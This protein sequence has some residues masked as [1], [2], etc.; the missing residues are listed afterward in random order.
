MG[1]GCVSSQDRYLATRE[2]P[3]EQN[4]LPWEHS[5]ENNG[6]RGG[7]TDTESLILYGG[8]KGRGRNRKPNFVVCTA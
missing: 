4:E 1:V 2:P 8:R 6:G 7:K 5:L 3:W